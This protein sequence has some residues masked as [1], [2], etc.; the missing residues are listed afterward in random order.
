MRGQLVLAVSLLVACGDSGDG[1]AG[2]GGTAG[3]AMAGMGGATGG[4]PSAT[5]GTTSTTGGTGGATPPNPTGGTAGVPIDPAPPSVGCDGI[6]LLERPEDPAQ[7]GPW[8]VG[9]RTVTIGNLVTE[10]WYPA[11]PGSEVGAPPVVYDL[12]LWLPVADQP[13][14]PDS[15]NPWQ[16]CECSRDLPI[17]EAH[18]P[19][20][21]IAFAHGTAA[22]RTQSLTQAVHWASRGFIVVAADHPGLFLGDFLQF[23]VNNDVPADLNRMLDA[24]ATASDSLA[25][26]AGRIDVTRI[27]LAGHSAGGNAISGFGAR[28]GVRVLIPMAAGGVQ[29]GGSLESTLV[30]GA[31]SDAIVAYAG[32][33]GGY[34]SSPPRKRLVGI[35][36]AGHLAF[37]DLCAVRNTEGQDLVAIAQEHG[38]TNA[39]FGSLLWDG[40]APGMLDPIRA[41]EIVNFATTAV[42]E[43]TL[44][45][46]PIGQALESTQAR[47]PEVT[48]FQQ[49]L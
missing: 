18:G 26:L 43:E 40:C 16:P 4:G 9:V 25:F 48:E 30:L 14:I 15:D 22:F 10:V 38:V 21:L 36:N 34:T 42:L 13:K 11:T 35:S 5:G 19:Y 28:P 44:Q 33:V 41:R 47:Y 49:A 6:P 29:P 3:D 17:D 39:Q 2:S 32:Q 20:P 45:C 46:S 12:R 37:S 8:P 24:L 31:Q 7:R 27:G 23:R 1:A